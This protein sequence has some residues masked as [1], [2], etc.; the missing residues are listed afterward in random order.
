M[1]IPTEPIGSIPRPPALLAAIA[2]RDGI[3]PAL[4]RLYDD[5]I[6]DAIARF[7]QTGSPVITDGTQRSTIFRFV[8]NGAPTPIW[9]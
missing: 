3:D 6:R 7:E 4:D 1:R 2:G 5:A 9:I 8:T